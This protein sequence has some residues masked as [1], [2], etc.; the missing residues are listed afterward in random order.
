[1]PA[2][3]MCATGS[4]ERRFGTPVS[5]ASAQRLPELFDNGKT[6]VPIDSEATCEGGDW[7]ASP[8]PAK[9]FH[10]IAP[11]VSSAA[12]CPLHM[13]RR[14]QVSL[15]MSQLGQSRP[16]WVVRAMSGLPP[17]ATGSRT[18]RHGSFVPQPDSCI[19]ANSEK[20]D[21]GQICHDR[22]QAGL[23]QRPCQHTVTIATDIN[24]IRRIVESH[25]ELEY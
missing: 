8:Y 17:V 12:R 11:A 3:G 19:A 13:L 23:T 24:D 20:F 6:V 15:P 14:I 25:P 7:L 21:T 1:M 4:P 9:V 18:L 22:R 10:N 16:N 2:D 5:I